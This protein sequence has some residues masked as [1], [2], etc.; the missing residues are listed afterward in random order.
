MMELR[1]N[2]GEDMETYLLRADQLLAASGYADGADL[3]DAFFAAMVLERMDQVRYPWTFAQAKGKMTQGIIAS[4]SDL[5]ALLTQLAWTEPVHHR[6][7]SAPSRSGGQQP[8]VPVNA[9]ETGGALVCRKCGGANHTAYECTSDKELR[10]C[11]HCG[12]P[13]HL[14]KGCEKKKRDRAASGK[15]QTAPVDVKP[16]QPSN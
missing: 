10:K 9:L 2:S 15:Q 16:A 5:R 6:A 13:G 3:G 4:F 1:Q 8:R 14:V 12:K 7:P 11:H